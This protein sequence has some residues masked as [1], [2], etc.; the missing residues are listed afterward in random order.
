MKTNLNLMKNFILLLIIGL[1]FL[2][3]SCSDDTELKGEESNNRKILLKEFQNSALEFRLKLPDNINGNLDEVVKSSG[4]VSQED[5]DDLITNGISLIKSYGLTEQE[6]I[7]EFGSLDNPGIAEAGLAIAQ[8][9]N[10]ANYGV[11]LI[12]I[13]E[14]NPRG[15]SLLTGEDYIES[16]TD[17]IHERSQTF[18]CA[19]QAIGIT[20]VGELISNGL[21]SMTK[22]AVKKVL[23]KVA[24]R[25][26]GWVGAAIAVYEF[27][28]CMEWW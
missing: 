17:V 2:S 24:T 13:T 4:V 21:K 16:P 15:E 28:D 22:S 8:I 25:Y 7:D 9:E 26:L 27:G 20:A 5:L 23:K 11:E 14:E 3:I 18:D 12:E 1:S 19:M 10:Q 6:I